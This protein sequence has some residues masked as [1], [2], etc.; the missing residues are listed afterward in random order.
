MDASRV[1]PECPVTEMAAGSRTSSKLISK[2]PNKEVI[3]SRHSSRL[4]S[5]YRT[6]SISQTVR[7]L[8]R[9]SRSAFR[10]PRI[11]P[12]SRFSKPAATLQP[13]PAPGKTVANSSTLVRTRVRTACSPTSCCTS[14]LKRSNGPR[15]ASKIQSPR[16]ACLAAGNRNTSPA[17]AA[18]IRRRANSVMVP[19][20]L[21]SSSRAAPLGATSR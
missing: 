9:L 6:R 7:P 12:V 1:R 8:M 2:S 14:P 20:S 16:I 17:L 10:K 18:N 4:I 13:D 11:N 15:P 5:S 21:A 19:S 3:E